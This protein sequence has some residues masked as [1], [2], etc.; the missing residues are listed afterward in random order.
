MR[1]VAMPK[2]VEP[3]EGTPGCLVDLHHPHD[4]RSARPAVRE[5]HRLAGGGG[6]AFL[7]F[8]EP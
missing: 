1:G 4:C 6:E 2:A 8:V 7:V 5:E 3:D